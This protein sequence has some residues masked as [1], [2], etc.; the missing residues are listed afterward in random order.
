[1]SELSVYQDGASIIVR[2]FTARGYYVVTG[3]TVEFVNGLASWSPAKILKPDGRRHKEIMKA[4]ESWRNR[5]TAKI[6]LSPW[7]S[8]CRRWFKVVRS[9]DP[10]PLP[11]EVYGV[12]SI[13][14][15]LIRGPLEVTLNEGDSFIHAEAKHPRK[16][17][18]WSY[19]VTTLTDGKLVTFAPTREVKTEIG[20]RLPKEFMSGSGE[21]AGCVRIIHAIRQGAL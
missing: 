4:V 20:E 7:N 8:R 1:M 9:G 3:D 2:D 14:G 21:P 12:K 15:E 11:E 6:I 5:R 19:E 18:G 16:M 10:L 13:P 17:R